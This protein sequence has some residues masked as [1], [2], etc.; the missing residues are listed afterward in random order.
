MMAASLAPSS[1]GIC[2]ISN[3]EGCNGMALTTGR[4]FK[5]MA[6]D[7]PAEGR[8]SQDSNKDQKS[9]RQ[10]ELRGRCRLL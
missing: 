10:R 4:R 2:C 3:R 8:E 6:T 1:I 7:Y 9:K 5:D